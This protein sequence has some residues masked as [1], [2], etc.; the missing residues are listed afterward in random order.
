MIDI[1]GSKR[2]IW[3]IYTKSILD[4]QIILIL[5]H[6]NLK[7][8]NNFPNNCFILQSQ[9]KSRFQCL[10]KRQVPS[11][12]RNIKLKYCL[13]FCSNLVVYVLS[14][15][16]HENT[17]FKFM[18]LR[19]NAHHIEQVKGKQRGAKQSGIEQVRAEL[20]KAEQIVIHC[21]TKLLYLCMLLCD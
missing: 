3:Y 18:R 16:S 12:I 17:F 8:G 14:C 21:R 11:R 1:S 20:S 4:R 9:I 15:M 6:Q 10:K 7:S 13:M 5:L 2:G 19:I